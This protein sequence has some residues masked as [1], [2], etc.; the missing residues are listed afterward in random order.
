MEYENKESLAEEKEE[1]KEELVDGMRPA[2]KE[3][4]DSYEAFYEDYV[5]LMKKYNENPSDMELMKKSFELM[6]KSVEVNEKFEAWDE[7]EMNDAE[8]K[9]YLKVQ[10]RVLEKLANV[11]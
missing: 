10:A 2:F 7:D 11:Q 1:S 3:A 9:Y 5:A 4:M 6:E 8:L